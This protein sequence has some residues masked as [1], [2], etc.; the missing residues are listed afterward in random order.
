MTP[1]D[2]RIE[3]EPKY[4]TVLRLWALDMMSTPDPSWKEPGV[5][6]FDGYLSDENRPMATLE[7]EAGR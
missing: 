2:M 3:S 5:Y 7:K 6:R 4:L 1:K